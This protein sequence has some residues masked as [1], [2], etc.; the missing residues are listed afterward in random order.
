MRRFILVPLFALGAVIGF[1]SEFHSHGEGSCHWRDREAAYQQQLAD[2]CAHAAVEAQRSAL[3]TAAPAVAAPAPA[4]AAPAN[5]PV[6]IVNTLPGQSASP[7][8]FIY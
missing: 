6:V 4:P 2:T 3:P 5:V 1:G 7:Q 8:P